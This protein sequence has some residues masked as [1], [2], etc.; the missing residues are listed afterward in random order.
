[1]ANQT[2]L[3]IHLAS[4]HKEKVNLG[5]FVDNEQE[6]EKEVRRVDNLTRQKVLKDH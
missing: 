3:S 1:M 4:V 5:L 6:E 2:E